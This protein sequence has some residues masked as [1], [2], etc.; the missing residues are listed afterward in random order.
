MKRLFKRIILLI[1]VLALVAGVWVAWLVYS[2][3]GRVP[4]L[5]GVVSHASLTAEVKVVRDKWGVPH[6]EAASE[7]D[8]YFALGYSMGQDRL[9]QMELVRRLAQGEIAELVGPLAIKVDA[10]VRSFRLKPKAEETIA[11]MRGM[12]PEVVVAAESFC[13]GLNFRQQNEPLPI[14]F[15][16]LGIAPHTFTPADCLSVGALLPI[17]FADGMREDP[18]VTMLQAKYPDRDLSKLFPSYSLEVPITIMESLEEAKAF[19]AEKQAEAAPG[20]EANRAAAVSISA[21]DGLLDPFVTLSDLVGPGAIGSNSWVISGSRTAS[22]KPILCNDPHIPFTNPSV[23]YEAHVTYPGYEWYGYHLPLIPF[24]LIGHNRNHAWALTML[25][26][27]DIDLF[28]ETFDPVNPEKVKHRGEW[29]EVKVVEE[30]IK[31]RFWPDQKLRIR[32][33]PNGPLITDMLRLTGGY[34]GPEVSLSWVWQ[35]TDYT[36]LFAF[37]RMSRTQTVEEFGDALSYLTSPGVNV[38]YADAAGN[39]AWWGGAKLAVR[40]KG[41]NHK[42]LLD[43]AN[44]AHGIVGYVPFSEN[45]HLLNPPVGYIVT[46]NNMPTVK[47]V[48]E[49]EEMQG[50]WQPGDRAGRIKQMIDAHTEPLT[51][52]DMKVMLFDDVAYMGEEIS[53]EILKLLE[54][55]GVALSADEARAIEILKTWDF[56][57]GVESA[58]GVVYQFVIDQILNDALIDEMGE[59]LLGAYTTFADHW[60]FFKYLVLHDDVEFWD[61]IRTKEVETRTEIVAQSFQTAVEKLRKRLGEPDAWQWGKVHTIE[62]VHPLGLIPGLR[63]TFNVGPLPSSGG[64]QIVNNMLYRAGKQKYNVLAGPSTRRIIDFGD[65]EIAYSILPTGNS[66]NYQ[67]PNYRDQAEMFVRGEFRR[68]NF[69]PEQI[70]AEQAHTLVLRP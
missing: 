65:P 68:V 59:K 61:D 12:Y 27:D 45:P 62:Y 52:E 34:E 26:N 56:G 9:F 29:T 54:A 67:S 46:A 11:Q 50:Y 69:T 58:G 18:T 36:D 40:P 14:E 60:N 20:S 5:D 37:Y 42:Q 33:T 57:H 70:A 55:S 53:G 7:A 15:E 35:K 51:V 19:L 17:A 63:E 43:G 31:V 44:E 23:W 38:S 25:A 4:M 47:P 28:Q 16:I 24:A 41:L 6:I 39:I 1:A 13:A 66:G 64:A 21:L 2:A 48:G 49:I 8:A 22:G 3:P 32:I 10:I 30:T